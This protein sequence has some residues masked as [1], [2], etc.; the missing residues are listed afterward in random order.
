MGVLYH[1]P[2]AA[3]TSGERGGS[4]V[5]SRLRPVKAVVEPL[6]GNKVKLSVEVDEHEFEKAVDAA[7]R[8]IS[9]QVRVPGFRPGKTPRRLLEARIGVEAARQEALRDSLPDFYARALE[10]ADVDPIAPPE[11]D[12]TAGEQHGPVAFDAVVEV[13]PQVAIPG[14]QGL[15]VTIPS[16]VPSD[17]EVEAQIDR[18][19][20][21]SGELQPVSR[22]IKDGDHVTIDLHAERDGQTVAE[23]SAE[24]YLYEV[25]TATLAPGLDE[26]LHGS[27]VGE[28]L[29]FSAEVGD[30]GPVSVRVLVKDVKEKVLP[31]VTDEW[32]QEASE[33][34]TVDALRADLANSIT[35]VKRMQA[36][37]ALRDEA[38]KALVE[39]VEEE[40]P[41][42]MVRPEMERRLEQ[43]ND[44]LE[45]QGGTLAEYL[46]AVGA[47]HDELVEQLR[48]EA[49]HAIKADLALRALAEAEGL[50]A[51]EE[52]VDAEV[53]RLAERFSQ[54]PAQLRRRLEQGDAIAAVRS[55]VRKAKALEWLI[56]HVEVVDQEGRHV[57]R[58]DLSPTSGAAEAQ[59]DEVERHE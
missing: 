15:R 32:A 42:N 18:L 27:K 16:P 41:E 7:F 29:T 38:L 43:L 26:Q 1:G 33:F 8:K 11:I 39:L 25:G 51:T 28:I 40:P 46:D 58:G 56:E 47:S 54:D 53:A 22:P 36:S 59:A 37:L 52:D 50:A 48:T 12:I 13:R 14:Y 49:V 44:R 30:D 20:Q 31:E 55:D 5:A 6:E 2:G 10:Q 34:D 3:V 17:E 24:D 23:L 4:G 45:A 57:D 21:Q 19:R 9:S 35:V